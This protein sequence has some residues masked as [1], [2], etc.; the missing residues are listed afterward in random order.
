MKRDL[1]L[2]ADLDV[3][4]M[5]R[6]SLYCYN[7]DGDGPGGSGDDVDVV[8]DTNPDATAAEVDAATAD[9]VAAAEAADAAAAVN[10]GAMW[11][12]IGKA[13]GPFGAVTPE[14]VEPPSGMGLTD[15]NTSQ[16]DIANAMG[17]AGEISAP[18]G[19]ALGAAKAGV[20]DEKGNLS[21]FSVISPAMSLIASAA[22]APHGSLGIHGLDDPSDPDP[23]G[24]GEAT[25]GPSE[26]ELAELAAQEKAREEAFQ[27]TLAWAV[28]MVFLI[29]VP[30]SEALVVLSESLIT[31]LFYQ[32]ELTQRDVHMAGASLAA[33][34]FGLLGHMLVKVLAPGYFSRQDTKTPVRFGIMTLVA[35]MV[36][37]LILVWH[38]KHVGLAL[39]TSMAAFLNAGLL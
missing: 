35:N 24:E 10:Y 32:G 7:G 33:Y 38:F 26:E 20:V 36:L 9:A 39:A 30:A 8:S 17:S 19:L 1:R 6:F 37:N 4:F 28:K 25:G 12:Q 14:T 31:T 27:E 13:S 23:S 3:P 18:Q 2:L 21:P 22:N 5:P 34:G 16:E 29:G 11:G 15:P